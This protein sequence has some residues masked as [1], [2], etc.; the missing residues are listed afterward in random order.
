VA[1]V[2]ALLPTLVPP[3]SL[4]IQVL[5]SGSALLIPADRLLELLVNTALLT[6]GV[7]ITAVTLGLTTAWI[8]TRVK[9][10]ARR[11]WMTLAALP[12]VVPSYVAALSLIAATGPGGLLPGIPTP[13]GFLGSWL[14]LSIFTAPLAHLSLIPGL[15]SIDP[16]T[17]EAATG[18]GAGRW[19]VFGTVTLPQLR[20]TLVASGLLVGLYTI[21]DFGAVSLLRYDTFTR[22]IYTLYRGQIDRRPSATLSLILM[23]LAILILLLERRYRSRAA[24]HGRRPRRAR[25]LLSLHAP[26]RALAVSALSLYALVSLGLPLLVMGVT[27][28]RGLAAGQAI[29][30]PGVEAARSLGVALIASLVTVILAFPVAMVITRRPGRVSGWVESAMWGAYS[31]PHIT[32]G[33][34]AVGFAL[35]WARPL[36]QTLIFLVII[37]AAIFL[38]QAVGAAQDSLSRASPDLELASRGLG[39]GA[40]ATLLR[41][42]LPLAV[43]GIVA[44][45][46]L[47]FLSVMKEL[48][49]TLLLRPN[50]FETLAIRIWSSTAEGFLT[51]ASAA[52]LVLLGVSIVPLFLV[53]SR[54]LS[55]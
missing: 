3:V 30:S 26:S 54:E 7:T 43:P 50:G 16:A 19:K 44:G 17:E 37:Y 2:V 18:L 14:V 15:R 27:L 45:A 47:V 35:A 10:P 5:G 32:V 55:D 39:K 46:A 6:V 36:Y 24:L 25:P 51:R 13:Y 42:T 23:A 53:M 29:G 9:L 22:A 49:A 21:S 11:T 52:G 34:A 1:A 38:P 28:S 33:V 40:L 20:P 4:L 41:V 48:P 12:L 31:L 8:T